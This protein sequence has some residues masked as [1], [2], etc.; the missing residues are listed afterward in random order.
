MQLKMKKIF[1]DAGW[2][3]NGST[4]W[5]LGLPKSKGFE[6]IFVVVDILFKY[7]HLYP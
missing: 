2:F 4:G 7:G 5:G 6:A 1:V 3:E